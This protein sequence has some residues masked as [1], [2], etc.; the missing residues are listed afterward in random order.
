[1]PCIIMAAAVSREIPSGTFTTRSAFTRD[2]FGITAERTV[3]GNSLSDRKAGYAFSQL[4][5]IARSSPPVRT[6]TVLI[7][8]F[9]V[10]HIDKV[11]SGCVDPDKDFARTR[12]GVCQ[13][14]TV[15]T[16]G[17]PTVVI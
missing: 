8:S 12:Y 1:M 16:S 10:V 3:P 5:N 11:H 4:F 6:A 14:A 9:S 13:F 15:R 2:Q 17:P 7:L